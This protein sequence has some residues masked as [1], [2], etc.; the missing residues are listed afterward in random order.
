MNVNVIYSSIQVANQKSCNQNNV[1]HIQ[2]YVYFSVINDNKNFVPDICLTTMDI[3]FKKRYNHCFL[4]NCTAPGPLE[5]NA[6]AGKFYGHHIIR[7][8]YTEEEF[9]IKVSYFV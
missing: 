7:Y 8:H 2:S 4:N 3:P 5:I 9:I 1:I 6:R